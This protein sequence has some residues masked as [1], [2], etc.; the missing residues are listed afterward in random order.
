MRFDLQYGVGSLPLEVND[1]LMVEIIRPSTIVDLSNNDL[2]M[3]SLEHPEDSSPLSSVAANVKSATIVMTNHD[4]PKIVATLLETLLT[5]LI[6]QIPD[7]ESISVIYPNVFDSLE[8]ESEI[9]MQLK[10][11][12]DQGCNLHPQDPT[13][14][15]LHEFVGVTPTHSTPVFVN[16][17]FVHSELRIG[18]STIHPNVFTGATGG[19]MA[20]IPGCAGNK[21]IERNMKLQAISTAKL[22][23]IDNEACL[24]LEEASKL[25]GLDFILNAVPDCN[26]HIAHVATGNPYT[27]WRNSIKTMHNVSDALIR[28]KADITIISAGGSNHDRTLYDALDV[29][30]PACQATEQG[31]IIILIAECPEGVGPSGLLKG[32]SECSNESGIRVL[33]QTRYELGMEKA[34]LLWNVLS[35]RRVILCSRLRESLVTERLHCLAVRDPEDGL[36][37]ARSQIVSKPRVAIIPQGMRTVPVLHS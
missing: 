11:A 22:Y 37:L 32:M 29:L 36:A 3:N 15:E 35:S 5:F 27:S 12:H 20:V 2:I 16:K 18:I 24:D 33:S 14:S 7:S 8:K 21:S 23:A 30:Y 1:R 9:V 4:D 6:S 26:S 17:A 25:A 10:I 31:G 13:S 34:R 28:Y 19:R